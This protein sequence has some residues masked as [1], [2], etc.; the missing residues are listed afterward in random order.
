MNDARERVL[1]AKRERAA[2]EAT[3]EEQLEAVHK[4]LATLNGREAGGGGPAGGGPAGG[5]PAGGKG[6]GGGGRPGSPPLPE[7]G[8]AGLRYADFTRNRRDLTEMAAAGSAAAAANKAAAAG[9]GAPAVPAWP[10]AFAGNERVA[11]ARTTKLTSWGCTAF[12][13]RGHATLSGTR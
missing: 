11:G 8:E 6:K 7:H 9:A 1:R 12:I 4:A 2:A 3:L 10:S 13:P 5:G